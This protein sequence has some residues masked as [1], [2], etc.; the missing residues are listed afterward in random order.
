[1]DKPV[2]LKVDQDVALHVHVYCKLN[3][4]KKYDFVNNALRKHLGD[5]SEKIKV[6]YDGVENET[7]SK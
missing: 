7:N 5:F 3:Q 1:M 6:L 2:N 4:I